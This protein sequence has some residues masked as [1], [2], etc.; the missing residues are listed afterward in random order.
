LTIIFKFFFKNPRSP[1]K[2]V[3]TF[4]P[5]KAAVD[6]QARDTIPIAKSALTSMI[7]PSACWRLSGLRQFFGTIKDNYLARDTYQGYLKDGNRCKIAD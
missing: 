7:N 3:G 5:I 1:H 6:M 2:R 4:I